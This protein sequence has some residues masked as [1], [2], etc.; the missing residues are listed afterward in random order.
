MTQ[1]TDDQCDHYIALCHAL[2]GGDDVLSKADLKDTNRLLVQEFNA[3]ESEIVEKFSFCP[4][5]GEKL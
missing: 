5:C 3:G 4:L 2:F 1:N